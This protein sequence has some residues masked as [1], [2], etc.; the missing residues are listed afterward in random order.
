MG[1]ALWIITGLL[2]LVFA[3]AGVMKLARTRADLEPRM[4]WVADAT[5]GQVKAVGALEVLGAAGLVLPAVLDVA[6]V[7]VPVSAA[8]LAVLMAGAAA[9]HVRR[10]EPFAD[11]VP[12]LVLGLLAVVVAVGRFGPAA[13]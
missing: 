3:A 7:L 11:A 9:T 4:A 10:G 5:D 12:A 13:F 2:A 6:P 1:I 8:A